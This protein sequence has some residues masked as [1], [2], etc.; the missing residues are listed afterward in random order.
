MV[1]TAIKAVEY[2]W[3]GAALAWLTKRAATGKPYALLGLATGV[4]FAGVIIGLV[5]TQS[6]TA[7]APA[8]LVSR[9]V[10][11]VLFPVGCSLVLFAVHNKQEAR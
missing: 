10:N 3:L 5:L 1:L 6:P 4:V 8:A 9:A 2:A 11:E 7:P